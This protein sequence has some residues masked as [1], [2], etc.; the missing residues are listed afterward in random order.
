MP[1]VTLNQKPA[2]PPAKRRG[3]STGKAAAALGISHRTLLQWVEEGRVKP[4]YT[5][6]GG[7]YRWYM[8]ELEQQ[9]NEMIRARKGE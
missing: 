4:S 3:V 9:V 2:D 7:Q 8:E 5:T 1:T 6:G